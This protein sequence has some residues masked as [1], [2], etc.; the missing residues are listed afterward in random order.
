MQSK[1]HLLTVFIVGALTLGACSNQR[2]HR[3]CN[4]P[5]WA[6]ESG[7]ASINA[8]KSHG[9]AV[10]EVDDAFLITAQP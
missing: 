10:M 9:E 5:Q 1:P 2:P 3:K 4:C 6:I 8:A 7:P